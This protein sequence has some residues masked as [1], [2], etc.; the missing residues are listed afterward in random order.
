MKRIL[1]D[2]SRWLWVLSLALCWVR[3]TAA[4]GQCKLETL[5]D[6]DITMREA[7]PLIPASVDGHPVWL[8][9]QVENGITRFYP[10]AVQAL[11]LPT[12]TV[13]H[14]VDA[15][16]S[17]QRV[18]ATA[19]IHSFNIGALRLKKQY[20]WVDPTKESEALQVIEGRTL[21][22][23]LSLDALW[24][25]DFELDPAHDKMIFY[26]PNHCGVRAVYWPGTVQRL[27]VQVEAM[28]D[29]FFAAEINGKS[30]DAR[31]SVATQW[32]YLR[33]DVAHQLF[34][35]DIDASELA[36]SRLV[37][38]PLS[39]SDT[40]IRLAQ[41]SHKMTYCKALTD[42]RPTGAAGFNDCLSGGTPLTLGLDV[43]GKLRMFFAVR[44][45]AIYFTSNEEVTAMARRNRSTA[46]SMKAET[47]RGM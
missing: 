32:T 10:A 11:G 21:L 33:A 19:S 38:G 13:P 23:A 24:H 3:A 12:E 7:G 22:G 35:T 34:G 2:S 41:T 37:A 20:A 42:E 6:V 29:F 25:Y 9:L 27:D 4:T 1:R 14:G 47:A 46:N 28:G 43:V 45:Q 40:H 31:I 26:A 36:V 15:L 16:Q 39:L 8:I 18:K 44:D 30:V 17:E 5:A